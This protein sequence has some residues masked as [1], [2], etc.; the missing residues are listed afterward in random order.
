[1]TVYDQATIDDII[2][3]LN[4]KRTK[5]SQNKLG[6]SLAQILKMERD[7]VRLE[8]ELLQALGQKYFDQTCYGVSDEMVVDGI[9]K[10]RAFDNPDR[11]T[12]G[13]NHG[14]A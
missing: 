1:M 10:S 6:M 5:F 13:S 3:D 2:R 12:R 7:I 9:E 11:D 4:F 8:L 14:T